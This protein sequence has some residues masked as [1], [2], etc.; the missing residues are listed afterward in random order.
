MNKKLSELTLAE[1]GILAL[2]YL[3]I[4]VG[5]VLLLSIE[6]IFNSIFL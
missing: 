4:V 2:G 6:S 1:V 5:V 3:F